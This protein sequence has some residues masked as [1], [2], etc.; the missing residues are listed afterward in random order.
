MPLCDRHLKTA[1][2]VGSAVQRLTHA[3]EAF[4]A[5]LDLYVVDELSIV[6]ANITS[7]RG[8]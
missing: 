4:D 8:T 5:L 3:R 1:F 7:S 2:D 6:D